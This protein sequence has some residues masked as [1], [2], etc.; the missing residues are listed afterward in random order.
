[1]NVQELF[2]KI[3]SDE[4]SKKLGSFY[5]DDLVKSVL[6]EFEDLNPYIS[7]D[8]LLTD[9]Q[10]ITNARLGFKG[11]VIFAEWSDVLGVEIAETFIPMY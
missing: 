1:M 4:L 10:T 9:E 5:P 7:D 6:D 3:D 11:A 8:R 2:A